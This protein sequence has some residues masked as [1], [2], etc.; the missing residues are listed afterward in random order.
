VTLFQLSY[1]LLWVLAIVLVPISVILVY[2]L[3]QLGTQSKRDGSGYGNNLIGRQ[4]PEFLAV[5]AASGFKSSIHIFPGQIHVVLA[6][7][8]GC[9]SC[10]SLMQELSSASSHDVAEIRM[11]VLCMGDLETCGAAVA[12]IDSVPVYLHDVRDDSSADLWLAGFPAA[13]VVDESGFVADIR[14]PLTVKGVIAAVRNA[15]VR[16]RYQT[17]KPEGAATAGASVG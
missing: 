6:L 7:S 2:L 3:A 4:L 17:P 14:H 5:D 9:T 10:K 11:L 12:G 8:S 13:L 16:D 15:T 1:L